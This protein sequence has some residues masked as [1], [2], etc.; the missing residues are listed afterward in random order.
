MRVERSCEWPLTHREVMEWCRAQ[1]WRFAKTAPHNPH[2]YVLKRQTDS[3]MFQKVVL[4]I[5]EFGYQYRWGRGEYTQ[6]RADDHDLWTMGSAIECTIL[7]NRKHATQTAK[8]EAEGK[9]GCGPVDPEDAR[10]KRRE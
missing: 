8:D 5:R 6:Y 4:H 7:I 3:L 10:R 1:R 9:A 2:S